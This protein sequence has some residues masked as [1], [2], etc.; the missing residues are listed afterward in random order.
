M[1]LCKAINIIVIYLEPLYRVASFLLFGVVSAYVPDS[2]AFSRR[3]QRRRC[4]LP[5]TGSY[6]FLKPFM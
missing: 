4:L 6:H 1:S 2:H 5:W 3:E